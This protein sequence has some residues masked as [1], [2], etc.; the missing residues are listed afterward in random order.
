[1]LLLYCKYLKH[2][3]NKI[4]FWVIIDTSIGEYAFYNCSGL[5]AI[6]CLSSTPPTIS[7]SSYRGAF[8]N[9]SYSKATLYVPYGSLEAYKAAD[10]WKEF[11]NIIED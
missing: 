11:Q 4:T 6:H 3:R 10:G 1:M 9:D 7:T 2:L 8:N 5:T